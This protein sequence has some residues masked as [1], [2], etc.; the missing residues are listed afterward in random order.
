M[1][2]SVHALVIALIACALAAA[3]GAG[4]WLALRRVREPVPHSGDRTEL[5][6]EMEALRDEIWELKEQEAAREKA[7]AA[8]E[9]KT[10]FLAAVSHE[11][12]TP[13]NGILG[14]AELLSQP[15]L[16]A[17]QRSYLDAISTSGKALASLIDE[18]LDF[19]KI[20]AGRIELTSEPFSPVSLVEGVAELLAP[21]AQGKG[22]EIATSLAPDIPPTLL[23]DAAR[24]RQILLNLAGNAVKFT[25]CG[26]VGIRAIWKQPGIIRIE[27]ADT[28]PG[29]PAHQ[30]SLIF[31]EF[32]QA[33][34]SS[35]RRHEGTGLGLA[36][37]RRIVESMGGQLRL[38]KSDAHGSVFAFELPLLPAAHEPRPAA[39]PNLS[40]CEILIVASSPFEAPY[41]AERLDAAGA[42]VLRAESE[43]EALDMLTRS[44]RFDMV[45]VDCALG[46][47]ATQR[48]AIAA[49]Q[50][51]V[52]RALVL[53]SPFERRTV[54]QS[55][56]REFDGWLVKPVRAA[57][58][59]NQLEAD[60]P[61]ARPA[62][63][64]VP[65]APPEQ[66]NI[67]EQKEHPAGTPNLTAGFNALVAEDNDINALIACKHLE[68]M[69]A[70]VTRARD[71]QEA[72]NEFTQTLTGAAPAFDIVLM[73]IRMPL[74]DGV[75]ATR[76]IRALEKDA[77]RQPVRIIALT[78]NAFEEDRK[79]CLAAGI[80]QFLTKPVDFEGLSE[81]VLPAGDSSRSA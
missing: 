63:E 19:A 1:Y 77:G 57:T 75:K 48:I 34:G 5:E 80:D 58:L 47:D 17:E 4:Y 15:D 37:S 10:R 38:E 14:M 78:A 53:L 22:L 30:Q 12:R 27:I 66:R 74:V 70:T 81:A 42:A 33:D 64:I 65:P 59:V 40:G 60:Q 6:T 26:G 45:I 67:Q 73:D 32:E 23:G 29:I 79:A 69:G 54:D 76:S 11:M 56:M 7:E 68:R 49:R 46:E 44:A 39:P 25:H 13:L 18:I 31:D 24:L 28:G 20:E 52:S 51:G 3:F 36:I 21:R 55:T 50:S 8:N 72:C 71:G 16:S 61:G 43:T 2:A 62:L 41:M 9:A 35:S